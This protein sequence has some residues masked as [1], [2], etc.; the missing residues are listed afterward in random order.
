MSAMRW[1]PALLLVAACGGTSHTIKNETT[2]AGWDKKPRGHVLVVGLYEKKSDRV[3]IE[4]V[5]ASRLEEKGLQ[6]SPSYELIPNFKM[7]LTEIQ[8]R[9]SSGSITASTQRCEAA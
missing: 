9:V 4:G 5:I 2:D 1:I 6:A 8:R 3:T 7:S